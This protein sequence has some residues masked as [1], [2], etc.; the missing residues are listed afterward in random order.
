MDS[1]LALGTA[2]FGLNYGINN[3]SGQVS[4]TEADKIIKLAAGEKISLIDTAR[5]YGNSEE[6]LG[7]VLESG[8]KEFMIVTKLPDCTAEKVRL[9]IDESLKNLRTRGVYGCLYHDFN[10]FLN[11][12]ATLDEL[13]KLKDSGNIRKIGFSLYYPDQ[14]ELLLAENIPF[15]LLQVPYNLLDRRFG[16]YF[17]E[18][19]ERGIEIHTRSVFLQGLFFKEYT[20]L[21]AKLSPF[22]NFLIKLNEYLGSNGLRMEQA[23]LGFALSNDLIGKV[24]VGVDNSDQL[25]RLIEIEK[26]LPDP[27]IFSGIDTLVSAE[28]IP[29]DLLIPSNWN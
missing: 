13:N 29:A 25:S 16:E 12:R 17:G 21:S 8:G 2:Q 7:K 19:K 6:V 18:L 4:G 27:E 10:T 15:E 28:K 3:K 1:R 9:F 11:D 23:A 20:Q 14:L 26:T 5:N 22:R 24:I